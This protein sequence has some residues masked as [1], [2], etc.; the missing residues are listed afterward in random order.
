MSEG[1]S[2]GGIFCLDVLGVRHKPRPRG[3][4]RTA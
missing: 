1:I 4:G 3:G 2:E